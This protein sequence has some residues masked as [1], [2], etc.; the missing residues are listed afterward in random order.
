MIR[1]Y[2]EEND[3]VFDMDPQDYIVG[4]NF[5]KALNAIYHQGNYLFVKAN[6]FTVHEEKVLKGPDGFPVKVKKSFGPSSF[7]RKLYMKI[8]DKI[9]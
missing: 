3:I 4:R 8:D 7:L 5:F 9:P 1:S 6:Y 2:C